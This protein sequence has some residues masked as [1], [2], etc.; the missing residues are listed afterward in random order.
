MILAMEQLGK[1]YGANLVLSQITAKI[2]DTDKIGLIGPNG[3]GK[4]TLLNLL[5]GDLEAD[6]GTISRSGKTMGFLRQNSGL[7]NDSSILQEMRS[8]FSHLLEMEAEISQLSHRIAAGENQQELTARYAHLQ[9]TFES[10][11]GYLIDVKIATVLNGMGFLGVDTDTPISVLSGG[12]KTRLA[13]CKL[14]LE[15]PDLLI[16]DEPTN[17]LDFKTL[18]WLEDYLQGYKGALLVVS[19][20]RYFLDRLCGRIWEISDHQLSAYNG[21]Y[22]SYVRQKQERLERQQKEY[23]IQQAQIADLKDFV[24][25]NMARASTTSRAKSKQ[26]V[27]DNMEVVERPRP[28]VKPA[29]IRFSYKREPV[30]DVLAVEGLTLAVGEG[31]ERKILCNGV[32]FEMRRGE[33]IALIGFNG[34]GK[35]TYLKALQNLMP[36]DGG[37]IYWGKNTDISY[38]EQEELQF[39]TG[40][41]ALHELWDRFPH[42]Y[43]HAIRTILG[44]VGLTGEAVHKRVADLSGG[45]RARLKFA[46]LMMNCGNV[47]LMDEPT[48]HL[49]LAT[50]ESLDTALMEYTG[51]LLIVSHDRYL[52]EKI[53]D[54]IVE[55][56]PDGFRIYPGRY[57]Q[58]LS[59]KNTETA[60]APAQPRKEAGDKPKTGYRN[61]KQRS[62]EVAR[63]QEINSLEI[64]IEQLEQDIFRLENQITQP[65]V[66]ANYLELQEKCDLLEEK[67]QELQDMFS[68]WAIL[69]EQ[70]EKGYDNYEV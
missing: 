7:G 49:D 67:R 41:T 47:L 66:A 50:K 18:I 62:E 46:V 69:S 24:A 63:K 70:Q 28:P 31:D 56:Y 57:A 44:N 68:Q 54:K 19:H 55:M 61:K 53:P 1:S 32:D 34:V 6:Q 65:E 3:A 14:L 52:L 48:N 13:L 11:E 30:K 60:D 58:Y 12:E 5:V 59:Q 25:R 40:K 8:V 36:I 38:F 29:K 27:L 9:S 15:S 43:E 23:E 2:E 26:K 4:S 22:S 37:H 17:H 42:S 20:D 33:K 39:D 16:L 10:R 64:K 35:S 51:T 45:E 21:N